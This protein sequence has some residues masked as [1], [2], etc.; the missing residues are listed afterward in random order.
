MRFAES[1]P[2]SEFV[3]VAAA[4]RP[5]NCQSQSNV[6]RITQ[7]PTYALIEERYGS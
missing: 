6:V 7:F 1:S 4:I 3:Q 2:R 5:A